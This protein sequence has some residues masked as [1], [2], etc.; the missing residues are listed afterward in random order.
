MVYVSE[1]MEKILAKNK[2][3]ILQN[4]R[5]AGPWDGTVQ[6]FSLYQSIIWS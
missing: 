3:P 5:V 2:S 6:Y 1:L 4:V